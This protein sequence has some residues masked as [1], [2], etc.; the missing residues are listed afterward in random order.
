LQ[1]RVGFATGLVVVGDLLGEGARW[2]QA[3][4]GET[5]NLAARLQVLAQPSTVVIADTTRRM[6]WSPV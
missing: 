5:P 1:V 4:I 6:G 2:E 3:V